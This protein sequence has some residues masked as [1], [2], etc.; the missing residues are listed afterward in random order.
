MP[1]GYLDFYG[2]HLRPIVDL[3]VYMRKHFLTEDTLIFVS[4]PAGSFDFCKSVPLYDLADEEL[5]LLKDKANDEL[6]KRCSPLADSAKY[7]D[8]DIYGEDW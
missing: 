8:Y 1:A 7:T 2:S 3:V 5:K 6:E 4:V